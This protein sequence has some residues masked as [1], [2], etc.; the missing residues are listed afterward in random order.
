MKI[1]ESIKKYGALLDALIITLKRDISFDEDDITIIEAAEAFSLIIKGFI[2]ILLGD[3]SQHISRAFPVFRHEVLLGFHKQI[4]AFDDKVIG[5]IIKVFDAS[6]F[7]T[8]YV[9]ALE[10]RM[11]LSRVDDACQKLRQLEV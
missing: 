9:L 2:R 11:E 3:Y 6:V 4:H 8:I 7:F 10:L 5:E 1:Y